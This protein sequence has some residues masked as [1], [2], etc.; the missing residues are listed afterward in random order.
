MAAL[1][2]PEIDSLLASLSTSIAALKA[3]IDA[4]S[5]PHFRSDDVAPHPLDSGIPDPVS[6]YARR[7]IVGL[8]QQIVALVQDPAERSMVDHFGF[9]LSACITAATETKPSIAEVVLAAGSDGI[10]LNGIAERTDIDLTKLRSITRRLATAGY[11]KEVSVG[12]FVPTRSTRSLTI[13]GGPVAE[14]T[15]IPFAAPATIITEM[16]PYHSDAKTPTAFEV[17]FKTPLFPWL[18]NH[19]E[20]LKRFHRGMTEIENYIDKG[21]TLD[22]HLDDLGPNIT[23]VDIGAGHG[24]LAMQFLKRYPR[25]NAVLQDR[26][27]VIPEARQFWQDNMP[28]AMETGRVS[29][30]PHS[31]FDPTPLPPTS[32]GSPYVFLIK[33]V[34]H[35]WPDDTVKLMLQNLLPAAPPGTIL[36]IVNF[37]P[38]IPE[39][40]NSFSTEEFF[41]K[42]KGKNMEQV[43]S[44]NLSVPTPLNVGY[45]A[46]AGLVPELDVL[47]MLLLNSRAR[48]TEDF[49][50]LLESTS[51]RLQ[52]QTQLR[53]ASSILRA[54]RV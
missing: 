23:L 9:L 48:T 32:D 41:E 30:L 44:L 4:Q 51:W 17:Y 25:W 27:E 22:V 16:L 12:R 15:G 35:N 18:Q 8:C 36:L 40:S 26:A 11:F 46:G 24:G 14:L 37:T 52:G 13:G 50:E 20:E 33:S 34:L 49:K 54:H 5:F 47:M 43:Q 42:I 28:E 7:A 29:F 53:G 21:V 45:G 10:S 2:A 38:S 19:P 1:A 31:F 6:F 3:S 39:I